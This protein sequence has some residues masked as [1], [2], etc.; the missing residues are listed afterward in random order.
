MQDENQNLLSVIQLS[1]ACK[2]LFSYLN[3]YIFHFKAIKIKYLSIATPI[4]VLAP[5]I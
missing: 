4:L 1:K 5:P 3:S 2:S